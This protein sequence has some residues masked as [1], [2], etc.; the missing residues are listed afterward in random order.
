VR[1]EQ[2]DPL[3]IIPSVLITPDNALKISVGSQREL[4]GELQLTAKKKDIRVKMITGHDLRFGRPDSVVRFTPSGVELAEKNE[5]VG[6]SYSLK[7]GSTGLFEF[8]ARPVS[9]GHV[10][11]G[12]LNEIRYDH[13]PGIV[14]FEPAAVE[15]RKIDVATHHRRIG[16]IP[17]AGDKVPEALEQMGF[18]VTL[19]TE[20]E[21]KSDLDKFDA[22]IT[23]VRAYNTNE[24]MNRYYEK[25][26]KYVHEGGNLI[27][28]YNTSNQIG[29]VRAR[30]GPYPFN[31]SRNRVTDETAPVTILKPEH[32][33]FN[34][35][36]KIT[37][38]DFEGW[39]QE[40][41]IYHATGWD[42][43]KFETLLSMNDPGE[44]AD[45]GS[46]IV[47]RHGKGVFTYTGIVFFRQ[48]PA[49]VPG[50]YRL[51]ANLIALNRKKG[52]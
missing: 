17:G 15:V 33:V 38:A 48:L 11:S 18:E 16:Y 34:Y 50:A 32:P 35:P 22:I 4:R 29:P 1:G 47:A 24:W 40:R 46:L 23:G 27:V 31:I 26:K 37:N 19:L 52:F 7:P 8:Y 41:S 45:A 14:Y 42:S 2:Y 28:Q 12:Q 9:N 20:K 49:G 43:T 10:S 25:L 51:L 5:T 6:V 39:I 36:N 44:R 21:M 30:I 3:V 13:I